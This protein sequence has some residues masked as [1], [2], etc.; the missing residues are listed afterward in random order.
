MAGGGL[1]Q[2][3]ELFLRLLMHS[4]G[5]VERALEWLRRIADQ[6]GLWGEN[7]D[8][9]RLREHLLDEGLITAEG[10]PG[11]GSRAEPQM[12]LRATRRAERAIRQGA[13]EELFTSLRQ[14][15]LAGDHVTAHAGDVAQIRC[16]R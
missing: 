7:V 9:D 16:R 12:R 10:R 14:D 13:F 11:T 5:D 6:H 3:R 15:S 1:G 2:L 4:G 8:M